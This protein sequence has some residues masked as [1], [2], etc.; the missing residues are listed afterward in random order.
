M[1]VSSIERGG[2]DLDRN[3]GNT[4]STFP[5]LSMEKN[6]EEKEAWTPKIL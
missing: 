2:V 5:N 1:K 3:L 6:Y 4:H